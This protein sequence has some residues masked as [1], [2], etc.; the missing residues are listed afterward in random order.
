MVEDLTKT[1]RF[2]DDRM[3]AEVLRMEDLIPEM[4]QAMIDFSAGRIAQPARRMIKVEP[5]GGYF[6]SMPAASETALG[7]KMLTFYPDNRRRNL[8]THMAVIV[9]FRP[10]TGE[11]MVVMDGHRITQMRTAAVTATYID[12]VAATDV[13]SLA[14]LGAGAQ[15]RCHLEALSR[16]R[17]FTDIRIWNR[18]HERAV[19]LAD[20]VGGAVVTCEEAVR[21]ADVVVVATAS[22]EPVFDGQWLKTG[23]KIATVGWS[24]ADGSEVDA[25][26]MSHT[27]IV[28]SRDGTLADSGNIR[29]YNATIIAELGEVLAGYISVEPTAT[30]VFD[31]I[32]MAC[33][34]LMAATLVMSKLDD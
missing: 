12:A 18:T 4:R 2:V 34:D 20:T 9:L 28:D 3:I 13:K 15:G 23:A 14:I 10:E 29:R 8:P 25:V 26:T 17:E 7:A 21:G 32:G 31:S 24:G 11:P 6:G 27:V 19:A 33:Q 22:T 16:V 5:H 30:V 1:V